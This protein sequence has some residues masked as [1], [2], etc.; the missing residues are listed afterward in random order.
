MPPESPRGKEIPEANIEILEADQSNITEQE[1]REFAGNLSVQS[2][3]PTEACTK[4]E[5]EALMRALIGPTQIEQISDSMREGVEDLTSLVHQTSQKEQMEKAAQIYD[6]A[7][8]SLKEN[9]EGDL[10]GI[11]KLM[12]QHQLFVLKVDGR[13]ASILGYRKAK[14]SMPDGRDIYEIKKASTL[15]DYTGKGYYRRLANDVL[16]KIREKFTDAVIVRGTKSSTVKNYCSN[17]LG[18]QSAG[19][20]T[21]EHPVAKAYSHQ[22]PPDYLDFMA[23]EGYEVFFFD[24]HGVR[25]ST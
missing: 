11:K 5:L 1:L 6:G 19:L 14:A 9:F 13:A 2:F 8:V 25:P 21:S 24:P 22:I 23:R 12:D 3:E 18:W 16:G 7:G 4:E 20:M 17:L 15:K 10:S